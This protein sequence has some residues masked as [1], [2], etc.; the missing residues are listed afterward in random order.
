M[1]VLYFMDFV[2]S[3]FR[4]LLWHH[5]RTLKA[6]GVGVLAGHVVATFQVQ[7]DI[8][9]VNALMPSEV[10]HWLDCLQGVGS[11]VGGVSE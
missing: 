4:W 9:N 10:E 5:V 3:A 6:R 2:T 1:H 11:N 8:R 7:R